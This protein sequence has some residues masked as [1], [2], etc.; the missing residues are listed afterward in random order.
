V[1]IARRDRVAVEVLKA[2]ARCLSSLNLRSKSVTDLHSS[3][4]VYQKYIWVKVAKVVSTCTF[5]L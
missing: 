3:D 2:R 5:I 4:I 1:Q